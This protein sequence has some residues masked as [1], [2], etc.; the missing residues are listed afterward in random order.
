VKKVHNNNNTKEINSN[1]KGT[2]KNNTKRNN[3]R[4][5]ASKKTKKTK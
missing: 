5:K 2:N 1:M 3:N 4:M